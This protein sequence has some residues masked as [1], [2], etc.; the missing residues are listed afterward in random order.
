MSTLESLARACIK[1]SPSELVPYIVYPMIDARRMEVYTACFDDTGKTIENPRALILDD[2]FS[3][4]IFTIKKN[5]IYC[6]DGATKVS[7][8]EGFEKAKIVDILCSS[9]HLVPLSHRA[10]ITQTFKNIAYTSPLYLKSPN[11]TIPKKKL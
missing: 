7:R 11:I 3:K 10:Y 2:F 8:L 6:G 5:V 4:K 9:R 1:S